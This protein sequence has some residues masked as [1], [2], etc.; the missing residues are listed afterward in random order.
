[1]ILFSSKKLDFGDKGLLV[2]SDCR[3]GAGLRHNCVL[4]STWPEWD[5]SAVLLGVGLIR[6]AA[7]WE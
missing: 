3:Q 2:H 1:M 6:A 7:L 4:S 5:A